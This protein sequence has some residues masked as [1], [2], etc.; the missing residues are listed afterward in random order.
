MKII[1]TSV[2]FKDIFQSITETIVNM[3]NLLA[4]YKDG[5]IGYS[6]IIKQE[7]IVA[8][9]VICLFTYA[10]HHTLSTTKQSLPKPREK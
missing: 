10:V 5:L 7:H 8:L 1:E 3:S 4:D 9:L 6:E 2:H